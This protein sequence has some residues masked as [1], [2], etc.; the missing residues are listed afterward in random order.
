[1]STDG[2]SSSHPPL[3]ERVA[4]VE[5]RVDVLTDD[6][7]SLQA[8]FRILVEEAAREGRPISARAVQ[9]AIRRG[10]TIPLPIAAAP[11]APPK[12]TRTRRGG[13]ALP[14][15]VRTKAMRLRKRILELEAQGSTLL[16]SQSRAELAQFLEHSRDELEGL[17]VAVAPMSH[18]STG[19]EARSTSSSA[20]EMPGNAGEC[21]ETAC[22]V[23]RDERGNVT[24]EPSQRHTNRD[25]SCDVS[26]NV[27]LPVPATRPSEALFVSSSDE[28]PSV[29]SHDLALSASLSLSGDNVTRLPARAHAPARSGARDPEIP[30]ANEQARGD[31]AP[32]GSTRSTG[33]PP[34][35]SSSPALPATVPVATT[36]Q[37]PADASKGPEKAEKRTDERIWTIVGQCAD[38]WTQERRL[39]YER[40]ELADEGDLEP[41]PFAPPTRKANSGARCSIY[42]GCKR[43]DNL[44][45]DAGIP[46][47]QGDR[48]VR[49]EL[50]VL[51][52]R[53]FSARSRVLWKEWRDEARSWAEVALARY[54]GDAR[55]PLP[56]APKASP[57]S[58]P[59]KADRNAQPSFARP[60]F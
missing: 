31:D 20:L 17:G 13:P 33:D 3:V 5:Q 27:T 10:E 40:G 39:A 14:G 52:F 11:S 29:P 4:R 2:P 45:R 46:R 19:S 7:A 25:V 38:A 34:P 50:V 57:T 44:L 22:D 8:A 32:A 60:G 21:D 30:V 47:K 51:A 35:S 43:A 55:A 58:R 41:P 37:R 49:S 16:A 42:D 53:L 28:I 54:R 56:A 36:G 15:A 59:S 18:F 48:F 1:M 23:T 12:N 24:P 6:V 9:L 26:G